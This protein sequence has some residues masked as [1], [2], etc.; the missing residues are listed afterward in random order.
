MSREVG[1]RYICDQCGARL[2]YERPC[3]C[4]AGDPHAEIC[5]GVQMREL[6]EGDR[7]KRD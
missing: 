2:V 5:C 7:K 3:P 6:K 4:P 1:D